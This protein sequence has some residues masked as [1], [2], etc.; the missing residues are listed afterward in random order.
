MDPNDLQHLKL[1]TDLA[2]DM[3]ALIA[4]LNSAKSADEIETALSSSN[5]NDSEFAQNSGDSTTVKDDLKAVLDRVLENEAILTTAKLRRRVKRFQ[6]SL[7]VVQAAPKT[8]EPAH[9]A[10]VEIKQHS[11]DM[12]QQPRQ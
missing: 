1:E 11:S 6:Q 2:N 12:Y 7:D 10:P 8:A 5:V 9:Y 3:E 4:A